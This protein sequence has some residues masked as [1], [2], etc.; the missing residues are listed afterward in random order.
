MAT[1]SPTLS[2]HVKLYYVNITVIYMGNISGTKNVGNCVENDLQD[3]VQSLNKLSI[4]DIL[5]SIFHS[6][7]I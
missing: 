2:L 5:S 6:V 7:G 1:A 4:N 3:F